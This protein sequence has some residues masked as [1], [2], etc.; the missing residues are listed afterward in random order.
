MGIRVEKLHS[1]SF[2]M[3]K[4]MSNIKSVTLTRPR[5]LQALLEYMLTQMGLRVEI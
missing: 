5:D 4:G 3:H 1:L 2:V